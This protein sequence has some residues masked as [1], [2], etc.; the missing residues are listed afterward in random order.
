MAIVFAL[1]AVGIIAYMCVMKS[2]SVVSQ[3]TAKV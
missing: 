2:S 3:S 1:L